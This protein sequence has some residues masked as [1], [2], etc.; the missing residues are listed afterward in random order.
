MSHP[1]NED[2]VTSQSSKQAR[3]FIT[4]TAYSIMVALQL[5]LQLV[6]HVAVLSVGTRVVHS[7][8]ST[9][10]EDLAAKEVRRYWTL[11]TGHR[12]SLERYDATAAAP[13]LSGGNSN[14]EAV[15]LVTYGHAVLAELRQREPLLDAALRA[16]DFLRHD[17]AYVLHRV[18]TM[19]IL[20][21]ATPRATLYAGYELVEGMGA[22]FYIDGDALPPPD[23]RL[24]L[25]RGFGCNGTTTTA[26]AV[27]R[28]ERRGIQPFHDFPMGPDWWQPEFWKATASQLAKL[29]MNFWGFHTYPVG[30]IVEPA[31]WVGTADG[32]DASSGD[33]LSKSGQAY[34]SSWFLTQSFDVAGSNKTRGNVPGQVSTATSSF[35]CGAALVFDRDCYGSAAQAQSCFPRTAD[36]AAGVHN[37]AAALLADAFTWG[38]GA[39]GVGAALGVEVPL[40]APAGLPTDPVGLLALYRGI[41]GRIVAANIPLEKFWLW[42]SEVVENHGT[43]KGLPQ[44]NPLWA[45]LVAE[46]EIAIAALAAT[47]GANFTLG[48]NGW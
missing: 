44:S 34:E 19:A 29:R 26:T 45:K 1:N 25:P 33:V 17:D 20:V 11:L 32:Y 2:F 35:C 7:Y 41:L 15:L 46:F 36:A 21:G 3:F 39:P 31:V 23:S 40:T 38:S 27:P 30:A 42:T 6:A 14:D 22:H 18:S 8:G 5:L 9:P 24:R 13:P 28:F 37:R 48:T 43:G 4:R 47:P 10:S 12:P 16:P